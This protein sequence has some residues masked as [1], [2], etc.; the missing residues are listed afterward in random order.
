MMLLRVA[1]RN[2]VRGWRRSAIIVAA[3]GFGLGAAVFMVGLMNGMIRQMT[4]TAVRTQLGHVAVHTR[5]YHDNP[6]VTR[7]LPDGGRPVLERLQRGWDVAASPR[8]RGDGLV[9]SARHSARA[10]LVGVDPEGE[11]RI[12]SVPGSLV[13]GVFLEGEA[14][15]PRRSR[16]LGPVVIGNRLAERLRVGLGDKVVV[17]APGETGLGAFRVRGIYETPSSEFDAAFVFLQLADAQRLLGVGD[18]VTEITLVLDRP[19]EAP[20]LQAWLHERLAGAEVEILRWDEREPQLAAMLG[21]ME[22]IYWIF[23]AAIFVAMAFG[24]ANVLFMSVYERIRE[25]GVLRAVG[26]RPSRLVAMV[27]LESVLLTMVGTA[28]GL[29]FGFEVISLLEE[30]GLNLAW[31]SEG[32]RAYGIGSAIRPIFELAEVRWPV[33]VA[34]VT[35]FVAGFAPA[36]RVARLRPAQALRGT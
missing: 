35:A 4:D 23:Y 11:A 8:L 27:L 33:G 34:A 31:F 24:I 7:S 18:R 22:N 12:S 2:L 17:H 15:A 20:A 26:L 10:V 28:V 16:A 6:D 9:Q 36:L 14:P 1:W 25:F 5:G 19:K 21:L 13:E 29:A 30:R 3:I 32:L